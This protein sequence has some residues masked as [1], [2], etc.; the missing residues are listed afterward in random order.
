M[1]LKTLLLTVLLS[2]SLIGNTYAEVI[3]VSVGSKDITFP[4][5]KGFKSMNVNSKIVQAI[6]FP[7][8][9]NVAAYK[10]N[11][12]FDDS[13]RRFILIW[14]P[15]EIE[16]KDLSASDFLAL[17]KQI[18]EQNRTIIKSID[19]NS[20]IKDMSSS[21]E[22]ATGLKLKQSINGIIPLGVFL[23]NDRAIG[24]V[25]VYRLNETFKG[26]TTVNK[27]TN[28]TIVVLLKGKLLSINIYSLFDSMDDINWLKRKA[29]L[30][31]SQ[32][33]EAN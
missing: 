12:K 31:S 4:E 16:N 5:L 8:Q 32:I 6:T 21:I 1:K 26:S 9:R 27:Q 18:K 33:I 2:T 28:A 20:I 19:F 13:R 30:W 29:K 25:N 22:E 17:S 10:A 24:I 7:G 11:N 15:K 14:T 23:E 3:T